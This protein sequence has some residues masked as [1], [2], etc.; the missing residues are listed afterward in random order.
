MLGDSEILGE[1][2]LLRFEPLSLFVTV[3]IDLLQSFLIVI[4]FVLIGLDLNLGILRIRVLEGLLD[5]LLSEVILEPSVFIFEGD[6]LSHEDL[7]VIFD[8]LGVSELLK[9]VFYL[10]LLEGD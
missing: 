7:D 8:A 9:Q 6:L 2:G 4:A 10:L 3:L 1:L 5:K